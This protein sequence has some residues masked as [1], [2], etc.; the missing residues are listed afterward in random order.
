MLR[1]SKRGSSRRKYAAKAPIAADGISALHH[2]I[3]MR[4]SFIDRLPCVRP[5]V[6]PAPPASSASG[7][8]LWMLGCVW[9]HGEGSSLQPTTEDDSA[10]ER[11]ACARLDYPRFGQAR[12]PKPNH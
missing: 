10:R 1:T 9:R 11:S 2:G 6:G 3:L 12:R 7:L 5:V 4:A 8:G